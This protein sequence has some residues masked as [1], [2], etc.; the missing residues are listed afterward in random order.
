MI[1]LI[2]ALT[3]LLNSYTINA[4]EYEEV[5]INIPDFNDLLKSL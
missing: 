5:I 1:K 3:F 4:C 2:I